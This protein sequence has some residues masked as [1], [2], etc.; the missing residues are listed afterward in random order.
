MDLIGIMCFFNIKYYNV[1][2]FKFVLFF[3]K[4][5]IK[6]SFNFYLQQTCKIKLFNCKW[7]VFSF[8]ELSIKLKLIHLK[9]MFNQIIII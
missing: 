1:F 5:L 8:A 4:F 9:Y 7:Y 2:I 6:K 3:L